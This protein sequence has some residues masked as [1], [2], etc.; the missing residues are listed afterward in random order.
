VRQRPPHARLPQ[1]G[2]RARRCT[3]E[4]PL[5]RV[6]N[7]DRHESTGRAS[8]QIGPSRELA[9][10]GGVALPCGAASGGG[11]AGRATLGQ[12]RSY[13]CEPLTPRR[14]TM[15]H[16]WRAPSLSLGAADAVLG[17][18][19]KRALE[20]MGGARALAQAGVG[21]PALRAAACRTLAA[22]AHPASTARTQRAV[23][24]AASAVDELYR[25]ILRS[26][27]ER[28]LGPRGQRPF[29]AAIAATPC[30]VVF[31]ERG[32]A[33]ESSAVPRPAARN[34]ADSLR[35]CVSSRR[36]NK[37]EGNLLRQSGFACRLSIKRSARAN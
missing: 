4:K 12:S 30:V 36:A 27:F 18:R 5:S 24:D 29:Y 15:I 3:P 13:R 6:S 34:T 25:P 1:A 16:G 14:Q 19:G 28:D 11:S 21:G 22:G 17:L 20:G 37:R 35:L 31:P 8:S 26:G 32:V 9:G 7:L 2:C 23:R 33:S 10:G